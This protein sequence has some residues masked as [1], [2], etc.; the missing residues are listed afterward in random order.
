MIDILKTGKYGILANQK[1]LATTS[2]NISN[3]NTTGYTRQRTDVYT[4]C[5]EWGI[6]DTYTRRIYN[7]YVQREMFRDQGN[8]GFY[9]SYK[10]GMGT[11]DEML[12]DDSMNIASSLNSYF[13]SLQDAVQ[14]PTSTATRQE[15]LSQL[16]IM[17]DRYHTLNHNIM[18]EM[19]DINLAVDDT[20][21]KINSLVYGIYETNK[22]IGHN[23][24]QDS[25]INLQLMD[26][27]DQLINELSSLVDLNT[28]VESD[29]SISVYMGNGQLL[30]NGDTYG[31]LNAMQDK[32]DPTRREVSITFSTNNKSEIVVNHK[33]W[34]GKLGG[35]LQSTDEIRQTMRDMGQLAIAFADAMNQQNKGGITLEGIA[36]KDLITLPSINAT[37]THPTLEMDVDFIPGKGSNVRAHDYAIDFD[38]QNGTPTFYYID[39]NGEKQ[40]L[41][42][43]QGQPQVVNGKTVYT[44][45]DLGIKMSFNMN[46]QQQAQNLR[47]AK[48]LAQPMVHAAYDIQMNITKPEEFAFASALTVNTTNGNVG[49][50]TIAF[51]GV[52]KMGPAYGVDIDMNETLP[53]GGKNPNYL[54]PMLN[55][56]APV[57]VQVNDDGNYDVLDAAGKVIGT[58]PASCNGQNVF[59][60][61]KWVATNH[62]DGFPG[63]DVSITGTVKP[64][65]SWTIAIN[66]NGKGDNSNGV[67]LGKLQSADLVAKNG[68]HKV[69]F[70]EG[71]ADVVTN[72]GA[73]VMKAETDFKAADAKCTQTQDMFASSAGVNLDEEAA[74]LVRFQ[75]TYTSCSK[76]IQA[77]QT[78][79]DSLLG[80]IK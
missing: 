36:G 19:H 44:F 58:A 12:S 45:E 59:A 38:H 35:L 31:K 27:R 30:V 48:V 42:V 43:P 80:A 75:Q 51:N 53:G 54:K 20:V 41:E 66:T 47:G 23:N 73:E 52:Y 72:L 39:E 22:R 40:T 79:F 57:K 76:I 37:T 34:G 8:K 26:K 25:D 60:N 33:G 15:L 6:G 9:E 68:G 61:T 56:G 71:Y 69:S 7:Q 50:A 5:I 32:L 62:P 10:T 63:Y 13:K 2:N 21:T 74:N 78:V 55:P 65:D 70:T 1:L 77:S 67:L 14:N 4:N 17:V 24:K 49:N 29:G 3:V 64:N 18:N 11:V 46:I 28:T 16:G